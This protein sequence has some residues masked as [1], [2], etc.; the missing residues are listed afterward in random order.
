MCVC[1]YVYI[2]KFFNYIYDFFLTE[3]EVLSP[4]FSK[5]T[6]GGF[7]QACGSYLKIRRGFPGPWTHPFLNTPLP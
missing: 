7:S 3:M 6:S 5:Y 1:V 4:Q 2:Y